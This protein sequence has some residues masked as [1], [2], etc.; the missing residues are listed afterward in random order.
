MN[1]KLTRFWLFLYQTPDLILVL[2]WKWRFL[3]LKKFWEK[4][5]WKNG[6]N[7]DFQG[8]W[9][10]FMAKNKFFR[11][12]WLLVLGQNDRKLELNGLRAVIRF[13]WEWMFFWGKFCYEGHKKRFVEFN[14]QFLSFF[15]DSTVE[16]DI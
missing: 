1:S 9:W 12:Y 7:N 13:F 8:L 3:G 11:G 15:G 5:G 10:V 14:R 2:S 16:N 4:F 6:L